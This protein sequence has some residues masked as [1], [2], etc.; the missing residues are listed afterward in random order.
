MQSRAFPA[1]PEKAETH[2]LQEPAEGED[3][4]AA[5]VEALAEAIIAAVPGEDG[6]EAGAPQ[7][8]TGGIS[9]RGGAEDAD[10]EH[11]HLRVRPSHRRPCDVDPSP[12]R[13]RSD[14]PREGC[15]AR[16]GARPIAWS[17]KFC[18]SRCICHGA[19]KGV[20]CRRAPR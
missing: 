9:Q 14:S 2:L 1:S 16:E 10:D 19:T 7:S 17:R 4:D 6:D 20:M 5:G 13:L 8:P 3:A 18:L 15:R 11:E 12:Q